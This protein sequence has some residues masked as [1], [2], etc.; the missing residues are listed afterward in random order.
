MAFRCVRDFLSS[1]RFA[2]LVRL[3]C[4]NVNQTTAMASSMMMSAAASTAGWCF[5]LSVLATFYSLGSGKATTNVEL[6]EI[7]LIDG[8]EER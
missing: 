5:C 8:F 1:C 4:T 7:F 2:I 6:N 3:V